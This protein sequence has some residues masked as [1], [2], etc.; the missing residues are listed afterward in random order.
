MTTALRIE[1]LTIR[2]EGRVLVSGFSAAVGRGEPLTLLGES[3]S[4]KSLV[5]QAIMGTLPP[6]LVAS[7]RILL[8]GA[9]LLRLD[10]AARRNLWGRRIGLLP[11]EPW[12]ALDPTMRAKGQL[13]EVHRYVHRRRDADR[14]AAA[15]LDEVGLT[16]A[17]GHYPFQ[18][19][20][21]MCQRLALAMAHAAEAPILLA[22]EPSKGLDGVLRGDVVARL[23]REVA[24]GRLL[25]TITH[26]IAL[27]RALGGTTCV[28]LDGH[29]VEAGPTAEVLDA[30]VHPYTRALID[31]D[32]STWPHCAPR[33]LGSVV[34]NG[35]GL[36]KVFGRRRLFMDLSVQVRAGEIVA[37]VGPSGS[38]KTTLG[39]ILVGTE[40][41]DR[42]W[43]QRAP[44][45]APN[46]FQKLYQDPPA[47]F[48]PHQ[49]MG[50]ALDHLARRHGLDLERVEALLS[51]LKLSPRLRKQR[52]GELSGGELQ[53][54]AL[55]RVLL[56]DP[57]FL[58]ADEATSRLDPI[59]QMQ[60]A[61]MLREASERDGLAI[62]FVTHDAEMAE[63]I[64]D[65]LITLRS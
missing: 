56:L 33:Q 57:V 61:G 37:V 52:P 7:G 12:T 1:D 20:G 25:L 41:P 13:A 3:G 17:D 24:A 38:G 49:N 39:N 59:N 51:R 30:P 6:G 44:G 27:A 4:G 2:T 40:R 10:G 19:S 53:R 9:D 48:V 47:A 62:L 32:P 46:R 43:V 50:R 58:F 45:A 65:R 8:D 22:D 26:D 14:H 23:Q 16:E 54:F 42:G 35:T 31:A 21:G 29:A 11:Q 5:A 64:A 36:A 28:M 34:I 60:V 18:M 63:R 15:G 55:A